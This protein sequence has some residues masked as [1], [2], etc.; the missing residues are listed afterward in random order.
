MFPISDSTPRRTFPFINYLI[1]GV[2]IYVFIRQ[3]L[4]PNTESFIYQYAFMPSQFHI[5]DP[6]TYIP[7]FTSLFLHGGFL[8]IITNMWFLHIF[9]DN[10][11]DEVGHLKY[12]LFYL[13]AG[14]MATLVQYVF[15]PQ[16]T[17]PMIGASGAISGIA[18]IYFVL[19][20]RSTVKTLIMYFLFW[21]VIEIPVWL[22]LGY[23]F[24]IQLFSG[25]GS[26]VAFDINMGGVAWFAHIG[27]FVY[28]FLVAKSFRS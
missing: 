4:A 11:E 28:G 8:H 2:T 20:R 5:F 9:G 23:W 19:F 27:G 21:D 17:T 10:V 1:I 22:F 13:I 16:S 25:V 3:L 15:I 24:L 14:F 12:L 7:I 18:G 6:V 26:L